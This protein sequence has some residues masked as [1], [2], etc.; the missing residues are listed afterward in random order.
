MAKTLLTTKE[1]GSVQ[2]NDFDITTTGQAVVTKLIAGTN[3]TFTSTG[4]DAGTGDVTINSTGGGSGVTSLSAIGSTPN[5]NAATITGSVL[6]LQ[7]ADLTYGGIVTAT[8]QSFKGAKTFENLF[9]VGAVGANYSELRVSA[10]NPY[11]SIIRLMSSNSTSYSNW[12]WSNLVNGAGTGFY[13]VDYAAYR[14]Q[15]FSDGHF[16]L[17]GNTYTAGTIA[18]N[19]SGQFGVGVSSGGS[20]NIDTSAKFQVDSTTQGILIPRV[21]TT[22]K[23]A[24]ATPATS[25]LV[26]DTT[27]NAY[28]FWN[29]TAWTALGGA[30]SGGISRSVNNISANQTLSAAASTDYVY[31]CINGITVTLP[32]AVGNTNRYSINNNGATTMY[33]VYS[34]TTFSLTV[35]S[36]LELLSNGTI[37]KII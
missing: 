29:G 9:T 32:T 26:F 20:V 13:N 37:W 28:S 3:I 8:T 23:N 30:G 33:V 7:P 4:V 11:S 25:L 18:G 16:F 35:D 5:A 21:T 34:G 12:A 27:L 24:I 10:E 17:G 1:I 15:M 36:T 19:T 14:F 31:F 22:Q 6:N 2:R